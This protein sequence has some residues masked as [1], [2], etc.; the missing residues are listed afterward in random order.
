MTTI[1]RRTAFLGTAAL[2]AAL[3]PLGM[4]KGANLHA[5]AEPDPFV[6][7]FSEHADAERAFIQSFAHAPRKDGDAEEAYLAP[8][9]D[10][11]PDA[12]LRMAETVPTTPFG[13][14]LAIYALLPAFGNVKS[15]AGDS[16][17]DRDCR[18]LRERRIRQAG[19][20]ADRGRGAHPE[21]Q[22]GG[23]VMARKPDMPRD[24]CRAIQRELLPLTDFPSEEAATE[25]CRLVVIL[26]DDE[27]PGADER[28]ERAKRPLAVF[29]RFAQ[30]AAS[31]QVDSIDHA[32]D[33]APQ[34]FRG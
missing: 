23:A 28:W 24:C 13:L 11:A 5:S 21:Q 12:M 26:G 17:F 31:A 22:R 8:Y 30:E 6:S 20:V 2:P 25:L 27:N 14:Y 3:A 29:A 7:A 32:L 1:N 18:A 4:A 15:N 19:P 10:A 33:L 34:G 9:C 16:I